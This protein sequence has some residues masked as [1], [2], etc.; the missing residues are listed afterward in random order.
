MSAS[1]SLSS[2]DDE[3]VP[4]L[5][6]IDNQPAVPVTILSGFLGSGKST[7]I[8][9]ILTSP[10]HGKRI[11]IIE[12]E[13]AGNAGT[14][15]EN[16]S[17]SVET[18]IVQDI[19]STNKISDLIEL[20]NGC[21]CCTVK[22]NLVEALE[23][24]LLRRSDFDYIL[25]EA[26]GM[27]NP[28]PIASLFWLD[29]ALESRLKLDGVVTMVD[30]SNI[31]QQLKDTSLE[32]SNHDS[33]ESGGGEAEQQIAFADRIIINKVDLVDERRL[34]EVNNCLRDINPS[35]PMITSSFS[36]IS[37]LDWILDTNCF[38]AE[39]AQHIEATF[40]QTL[41]LMQNQKERANVPRC[42]S[43]SCG[44]CSKLPTSDMSVESNEN[45][46]LCGECTTDPGALVGNDIFNQSAQKYLHSH[47]SSVGT[48]VLVRTGSVSLR[49][50]NSFLATILWPNQDQQRTSGEEE[51]KNRYMQIFRIKGILSV[52]HPTRNG[53]M[54]DVVDADDIGYISDGLDSRRY[55]VQAVNDLWEI[56]PATKTLCWD[57]VNEDRCCKIILIGRRLEQEKLEDGFNNCFV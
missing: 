50:M 28:G 49:L 36:K 9:N 44:T 55:I 38:D 53:A 8:R 48:V 42:F 19:D 11:A 34:E 22:D 30:S 33:H 15:G 21:I 35:V 56:H 54:V 18:M 20:P 26:S 1:V 5:L 2:S 47:T 3:D 13:F 41:K 37:D 31:L 17:L 16:E 29:E 51:E 24:L 23:N 14:S 7:L 25:I 10:D 39:R 27:A 46:I 57:D 40:Q 52:Q 32:Q 45:L 6:D 4:Q 12:N 43:K